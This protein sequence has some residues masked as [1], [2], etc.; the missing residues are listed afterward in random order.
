MSNN[1]YNDFPIH[2]NVRKKVYDICK[3]YSFVKQINIGKSY[4]GRSIYGLGIGNLEN[5]NLA[6]GAVH[7]GEYL[8][9]M[10]LLKHFEDMLENYNYELD[11]KLNQKGYLII[12]SLNPDGVDIAING[13]QTSGFMKTYVQN[14]IDKDNRVWHANAK[15]VDINHN[16][17][18]K[19]EK[20]KQMEI[21][22]GITSPAPTQYGGE[23]P[24]SEPE[25]K[26][27]VELCNK[28]KVNMLFSYHSQGE[29][30]YY[31]FGENTPKQAEQIAKKMGELSGYEVKKPTGLASYGGLKD[32]FILKHKK[33]GFTI[34]IG[35]G[36]NPLPLTDFE[37][38]YNKIKSMMDYTMII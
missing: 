13:A 3:K 27:I 31:D 14:I 19:F 4:L 5:F 17:D 23:K 34:E 28:G 11:E 20:L 36:K 30:I 37:K 22:K 18:A 29:E 35:K 15:G 26:E 21:S 32:W 1:F 33:C 9:T 6:V 16:F 7:G 25:T 24:H 12:P 8:T 38:I 2:I 10:V